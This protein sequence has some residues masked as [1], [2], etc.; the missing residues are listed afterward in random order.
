MDQTSNQK[1]EIWEHI[2]REDV[3]QNKDKIFLFGDNLAEK[4]YGGQAK[5][6]RGEENSVGI[7]TK[8]APNNNQ[9][10][11]FTDKEFAANIKVVDEAFGKISP[12]K[13]IVIPKAGIGTGLAKLAENAPQTFAHL[14]KKF[15]EIGFDN[16]AGRKILST[17]KEENK[18]I[19]QN[20]S[21][22]LTGVKRLLDL[23]NIQTAN[24]RLLS[25]TEKEVAAIK[26]DRRE[27]LADYA[28]RLRGEYKTNK[29]NLRDGF[30][31]LSD[32]ID[33]GEQITV[34]C[35]CRNGEM[36]HADVVKMAIEKVNLHIKKEQIQEAGRIP[37]SEISATFQR[38]IKS[39][40]ENQKSKINPRTQRAINEILAFS[41]I[42]RTLEKI[43]QTD[44]RNRSEQASYLGKTSQF[45][46]DIYERGGN[47]IGGNLIVPQEKLSVSQPLTITTQ[48]Y[49]VERIGKILHDES[50]AKEI[51][52]IIVEYGNKIAG[53]TAD[54]ETKLKVFNWIYESLEG[55]TDFLRR[56]DDNQ[57]SK[58]QKFENTLAN[59]QSLA[60][61][62]H[63]LE[64]SDKLEFVPLAGFEQNL[65]RE[66]VFDQSGE[67]LNLEEIYETAITRE[68]SEKQE[69]LL[70]EYLENEQTNELETDKKINTERFERIELSGSIPQIPEEF[71]ELEI[72]RLLTETLPEID[73]QLENGVSQK[74]ILKPYNEIVWQ[75]KKDD[76]LGR[77]EKIYQKQKITQLDAKLANN[78]LTTEQKEKLESE[79]SLWKAAVL[80]P[81]QEEMREILLIREKSNEE[82]YKNPEHQSAKTISQLGGFSDDLSKSVTEQLEKIDIRRQN[83]IEL[84]S[85]SEYERAEKTAINNFFRQ[86]KQETGNL[87]DKIDEIRKSDS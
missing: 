75:S 7:P 9:A 15:A 33:K 50:K 67:N 42:D 43:N 77:L 79:K 62:M 17:S 46:R 31:L 49:A 74:E 16:Q 23:D 35:S 71:S 40:L 59:I 82:Q 53:T 27:A 80:T 61:E 44:G 6:M 13:T 68:E 60:E 3:R 84:K 21:E 55:K 34:T 66:T 76:A 19:V 45:V 8:K 56:E 30:R 81:T 14:N 25:P 87:L 70:N 41:E 51:A 29:E 4:G 64:P 52:P 39:T 20:T 58:A 38:K 11:F 12:N 72:N 86:S 18:V 73:R 78:S 47:V 2:T 63:S 69:T 32:S 85:P 37:Q 24:L 1:I 10:S 28:E 48:D 22:K 5:E 54:G 26:F 57:Q 65:E 83:V 36:C